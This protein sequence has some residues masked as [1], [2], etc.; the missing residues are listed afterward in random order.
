MNATTH[1]SSQDKKRVDYCTA[2]LSFSSVMLCM[3]GECH[4]FFVLITCGFSKSHLRL[5]N[6][7][8]QFLVHQFIL[9]GI[10]SGVHRELK[11]EVNLKIHIFWDVT[12]CHVVNSFLDFLTVM[13]V[14]CH[15]RLTFITFG[16]NVYYLILIIY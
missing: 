7:T 14:P 5:N 12:L 8:T 3:I 9:A 10:Y 6:T 16:I 2:A 15:I 1:N 4:Y 11:C 13:C